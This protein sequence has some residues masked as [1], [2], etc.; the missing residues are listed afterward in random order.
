[1]P[2]EA[3]RAVPGGAPALREPPP[4][5][6][7]P[8]LPPVPE[9]VALLARA[10]CGAPEVFVPPSMVGV[11]LPTRW[12]RNRSRGSSLK[13]PDCCMLPP[14]GPPALPAVGDTA[15]SAATAFVDVST[16]PV[17][18]CPAPAA[19]SSTAASCAPVAAAAA[20]A[21]ATAAAAWIDARGGGGGNIAE[22]AAAA[23]PAE[24]S[25]TAA[26]GTDQH[27][28]PAADG[29]HRVIQRPHLRQLL[30]LLLLLLL[31][32]LCGYCRHSRP[33]VAGADAGGSNGRG[34]LATGAAA[35]AK[36]RNNVA[37]GLAGPRHIGTDWIAAAKA[38]AAA[39][40]GCQHEPSRHC[41]TVTTAL[42]LPQVQSHPS[43][44]Q[45]A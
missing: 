41:L 3:V 28:H 42:P 25:H 7:L 14:A 20:A 30:L 11:R 37:D 5:P 45:Q 24:G 27:Q 13:D 26:A 43:P 17:W 4:A 33:P 35:Q 2:V 18:L 15:A 1:M 19:A 40:G 22:G 32:P 31:L 39:R 6:P 38:A 34:H 10:A 16:T 12:K 44:Q 36:R 21:A 9:S 23:A 8:V 29:S